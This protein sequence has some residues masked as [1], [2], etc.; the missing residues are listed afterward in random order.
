[1]LHGGKAP[2][3]NVVV[4]QTRRIAKSFEM[5]KEPKDE[6]LDVWV[7]SFGGDNVGD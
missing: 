7:L 2:G 5:E 4:H 3:L 1:M 6:E